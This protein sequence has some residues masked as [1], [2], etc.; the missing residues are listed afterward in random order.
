MMTCWHSPHN[1]AISWGVIWVIWVGQSKLDVRIAELG[2]VG[3][4]AGDL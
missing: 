4:Q 3:C 1:S 2:G